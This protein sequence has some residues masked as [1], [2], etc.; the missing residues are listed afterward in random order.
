MVW[1]FLLI[2]LVALAAGLGLAMYVAQPALMGL[3]LASLFAL[4]LAYRFQRQGWWWGALHLVF[5]FAL[6][7]GIWLNWSSW[8]W[9][10]AFVV[11]WIVC[12]GALQ[13]RVPLYLSN[14]KALQ[15][16]ASQI[17]PNARF[18]DL[19][20][21]TGTA[22]AWLAR[23]RPD[24]CSTGIEFAW[25]PWLIGRLRLRRRDIRWLRGDLFALPLADYDVVYA[26][27]SPAPMARLWRKARA[28]MKP[29]AILI[30]NSFAIPD[31]E[32][33]WIGAVDDWKGSELLLWRL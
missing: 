24:V 4:G 33:D 2:Q 29:G 19:G 20:A 17:P 6:A 13:S 30:S 31:V 32:P 15:M 12:A 5:P 7:F 25:L 8:V 10:A 28:E 16:L 21:G 22:L 9:L 11:S 23:H 14:T 27:L 3:G 18:I 1:R 26:Y